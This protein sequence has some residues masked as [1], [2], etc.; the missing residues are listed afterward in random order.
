MEL[1]DQMELREVRHFELRELYYF[2]A[3]AEEL[4]FARAADRVGIH[5]SPL[6]KAITL[7]ER[8]LGV[9][10][11]VRDRRSTQLTTVG[12]AL[13]T[14]ARRILAE[15]DQARRGI[16]AAAAGRS[17]RL[18]IAITDGLAQPRVAALLR[19]TY[20]EDSAISVHVMQCSLSEQLRLLRSGLLDV[21]LTLTA[22]DLRGFAAPESANLT[23]PRLTGL[24]DDI[25][26]SPIWKD[27]LTAVLEREHP[28]ASLAAV[29]WD[30]LASSQLILLGERSI[31]SEESVT[32][33]KLNGP[34]R[35]LEYVPSVELLLTLA[36]AGKGIGLIGAA[37]ART[38]HRDDLVLRP[39]NRSRAKVTTFL[40]RRNGDQS[41]LVD[42]FLE[43]VQRSEL[44]SN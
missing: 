18:R 41:P 21:G 16:V 39:L 40:L 44:K 11:F 3:V 43:R 38:I 27:A 5:Q 29:D 35:R 17:G 28:L 9:R 10:L 25:D 24:G 1:G 14:D 13:L 2:V 34:S 37:L 15:A 19:R 33:V 12:E 36:A 26:A 4:H 8:H 6:S 31:T 42:R 32:L 23:V 30:S 7:M 22:P 20:S